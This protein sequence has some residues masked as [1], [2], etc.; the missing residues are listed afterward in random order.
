MLYKNNLCTVYANYVIIKCFTKY[1]IIH[2]LNSINVHITRIPC[3]KFG[4]NIMLKL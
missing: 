1:E 4:L 3:N 2:L